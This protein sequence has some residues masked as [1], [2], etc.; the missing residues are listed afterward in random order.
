MALTDNDPKKQYTKYKRH[1]NESNERI[2]ADTVNTIQEDVNEQQIETNKIKDKAF[3]ERV[4]TIFENNLYTNAMFVDTIA[5][6]EYINLNECQNVTIDHNKRRITLSDPTK[7]GKIVS[8]LTYSSY[9]PDVEL[10]DF[11]VVSNEETP[12]GTTIKFYIESVRGERWPILQ[13]SLKLPMHLSNNLEDGFKTIIE[14]SPNATNESPALNCYAILYWDA[15]IEE[16]LGL[17]NPDLKRFP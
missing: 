11:F 8:T 9:G 7:P 4:Y 2:S 16:N 5:N 14:I 10:N 17:T 15:K 1:V 6:G 12:I 13:N 3:E